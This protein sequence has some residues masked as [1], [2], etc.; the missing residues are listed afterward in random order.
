M[1]EDDKLPFFEF[2]NTGGQGGLPNMVSNLGWYPQKWIMGGSPPKLGN[3][4]LGLCK[5]M[6]SMLRSLLGV[7]ALSDARVAPHL[8]KT[9]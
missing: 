6:G 3:P 9:A 1:D 8:R 7:Q 4:I 2:Q 5:I